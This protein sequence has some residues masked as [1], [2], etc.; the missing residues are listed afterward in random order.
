MLKS[1]ATVAASIQQYLLWLPLSDEPELLAT[2]LTSHIQRHRQ[3]S[4]AQRT[5]LSSELLH[6][7]LRNSGSA[8]CRLEQT[9]KAAVCLTSFGGTI[10]RWCRLLPEWQP[11]ARKVF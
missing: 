10:S 6:T 2:V 9:G 4:A 5:T 1:I 8:C 3:Q 7:Q 11:G